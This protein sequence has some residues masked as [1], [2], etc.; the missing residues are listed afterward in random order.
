M[1]KRTSPRLH[2]FP[3]G[4]FRRR[5]R[6]GLRSAPMVLRTRRALPGILSLE[7]WDLRGDL[8]W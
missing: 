4:A 5:G 6:F 3:G 2:R 8:G 7:S 1:A